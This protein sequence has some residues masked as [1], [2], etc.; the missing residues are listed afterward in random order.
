[1]KLDWEF[2]EVRVTRQP[3]NGGK[4][5]ITAIVKGASDAQLAEAEKTVARLNTIAVAGQALAAGL[6]AEE[7]LRQLGV[8]K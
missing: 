5:Y 4:P 6:S 3:K 1:M 2:S 7:I 8:K